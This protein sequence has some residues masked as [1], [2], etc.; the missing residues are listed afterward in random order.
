MSEGHGEE[1]EGEEGRREGVR[2]LEGG[3]GKVGDGVEREGRWEREEKN[4]RG[5]KEGVVGKIRGRDGWWERN[6]SE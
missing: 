2:R 1:W 4:V 3:N 5:G 6:E